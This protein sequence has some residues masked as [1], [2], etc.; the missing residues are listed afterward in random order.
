MRNGKD[1]ENRSVPDY[2]EISHHILP[3]QNN[4]PYIAIGKNIEGNDDLQELDYVEGK[5]GLNKE[6][7]DNAK[8]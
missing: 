1:S 2:N 5:R 8:Q 6:H 7:N 3:A 4:I